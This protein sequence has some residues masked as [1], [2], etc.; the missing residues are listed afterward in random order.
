MKPS[1]TKSVLVAVLC[2]FG[3]SGAFAQLSGS[4]TIDASS[5]ASNNYTSVSAA[6]SALASSGVSGAVTFTI[7]DGTYTGQV[8]F[9]SAITGASST[10]TITFKSKSADAQKVIITN[11]GTYTVYMSGADY[12]SFEDVTIQSTS[13]GT[14]YV[15]YMTSGADYNNFQDCI[16]KGPQNTWTSYSVYCYQSEFNTWKGCRINGNY[17]GFRFWG[18]SDS[19]GAEDNVVEDCDISG[20]YYYGL[21]MY[22]QD[23]ITIKNCTIDS[24][25]SGIGYGLYHYRSHGSLIDG[26]EINTGYYP[27]YMGYSNYYYSGDTIQVQNNS[28]GNGQY[29]GLYQF[30]GNKVNYYHNSFEA[31]TGY[32]AVYM[33]NYQLNEVRVANNIFVSD[34][35]YYG[36]Y[37]YM[38]GTAYHPKYWDYNDYWFSNYTYHSY[39]NG[40]FANSLTALKGLYSSAFNQNSVEVDPDWVGVDR[41]TYTPGLNNVGIDKGVKTDIDGNARP[42]TKDTNVDIGPNDYWLADYDLD[43]FSLNSPLSVSLVSNQI[44]ATFKNAGSKTISNTDVYVEYSIDS[45]KT[46]VKDTMTITS[47]DPGKTQTFSFSKLWTPGRSGNFQVSVRINPQITGDPDSKDQKDWQVCSG[48][49]GT[50]TIGKYGDFKTPQDAVDA[51]KCGVA[52]PIVFDI[53]GGVYNGNLDISVLNG[54]SATNT[55]TFRS[56]STDSVT[57]QHSGSENT[58]ELEGADYVSFENI[59]ILATG[60]TG[61]AVHLMNSADYNSFTGCI[62]QSNPTA[63]NTASN[64]VVFSSS[65][66]SQWG[67]GNNGNYNVFRDNQMI[68]GY[69]GIS[70]QGQSTTSPIKGNEFYN[71]DITGAYYYGAYMYYCDSVVF[72]DNTIDNMRNTYA[73]GF[74]SYY[75]S[76]FSVERNYSRSGY[77]DFLGQANYYNWNNTALSTYANNSVMCDYQY[78]YGIYGYYMQRVGFYHN[79]ISSQGN[80]CLYAYYAQNNDIR[81]NIFYYG[82]GNYLWYGW[83]NSFIEFDYNDYVLTGSGNLAYMAGSVLSNLSALKGWNS[84]YNQNSF[85]EDP[86]WVDETSD[87]HVTSKFPKMYGANVGVE[88]DGDGDSRCKFAPSIGADEFAQ[89][90]LPPTASFLA[91]DTA[92]LGSPAIMLNSNK[93]SKLA[94]ATWFVNDTFASDSIHLQYTPTTTGMDTIMLVMENCSGTDTLEKLVYVSPILRAPKVDFAATST[95]VYTNEVIRFLDLSSGG[96]TSWSWDISPRRVY[97]PF[98]G[99][100]DDAWQFDTAQANPSGAFFYPG[101]Y[102]VKLKVANSFGADS[103]VRV[104]YIKVRQRSA[105][106]DIPWDTDGEYGTL[107]DNG[108][109]D[110]AYS[111]GLNGLNKCTYLISSCRGEIEFDVDQFDLGEDDYLRIYDG[112]D[113]NGR[114]L[115]DAAAYPDGMT[116]NKTNKS[117]K[118]SFTS[119]TGSAYFVFESDNSTQTVGKGF[120]IDWEYTPVT[121]TNPTAAITGVDTA[122]TGFPTVFENASTGNWSYVEWDIDNDGTIDGSGDFF[123]HTFNTAG[124]DT[125]MLKAYSLCAGADSIIKTI[126]IEDATKPAKPDFSASATV[127]SAGDTVSIDGS[128]DYCVSGFSWEI[129]PANYLLA[130]N[131]KLTDESIDIVFTKGGFFTI[132][133]EASNPKGKDSLIKTNYIQV[134]DYCTPSVVNIDDDLGISRVVFG[135]IDNSSTVGKSA[136]SNYTHISTEV[137]RGYSYQLTVERA[138]ANKSMNRKVWIDWNI[139]GDFDDAGELVAVEDE[140]NSLSFVDTIKIDPAAQAGKTRMRVGTSYKKQK[141]IACGPHAF[142]EFEDYGIIILAD[143]KTAPTLTLEGAKVDTIEVFGTWTEPG[144]SATDLVDGN[145]TSSVTVTNGLDNTVLG[146]YSIVYEVKDAEGNTATD[147]RTIVVLDRTM[148]THTLDGADSVW[149][150]IFTSYTDAGSTFDDNYDKA[151]TR[152]ELNNVDTA[153]LGVY[154]VTYCVTDGSGNGPVCVT[155]VVTVFDTIAPVIALEGNDPEIVDVFSNYEDAGFTAS[156]NHD[157]TVTTSGTWDGTVDELGTFTLTYTV[158]DPAGNSA[159]VTRTIEVVD[160]VAP[161]ITL[162]GNLVETVERWSDYTDANVT[163]TDNYDAV[164]DITVTPGGTFVNTQS[165]G[166]YTVTY[167]AE[168]LSGNT[169]TTVQRLVIVEHTNT[170]I[171]PIAENGYTVFPNPSN[172]LLVV[173]TN[174]DNGTST[175]LR[176]LDLTGKEVL[177]VGNHVVS[178][179]QFGVDLSS[180]ATGTYHLEITSADARVIEQVVIAR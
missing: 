7:S 3:I 147:N 67:Y 109:V 84:N 178:N 73:Y 46:W 117:V 111:P 96:A 99:I 153:N 4:Y 113:D 140:S 108:G 26:N 57:I 5:S 20:H 174:L 167:V 66:T 91:P 139:D 160:R 79:S 39:F 19:D 41:R 85:E 22:Y 47:M 62:I 168:D 123:S 69:Y 141:N 125:I 129:T 163:V 2:L 60:G 50:F 98:F 172:G 14:R 87:L 40:S 15:V 32:Y 133:L 136:Y 12:I 65:K 48:L 64:P 80:Y 17:Y 10:N 58:I 106:C 118:L 56:P 126:V 71:N 175:Q 130:N 171:D 51:L 166:V 161:E 110:G 132:E 88:L 34:G 135:D 93:A 102:Q 33:Y 121:W 61:F 120:A 11:T 89:V 149:V 55:V 43:V 103:V 90:V 154:E 165:E 27:F 25:Q 16:I 70:L 30:Y 156:D 131:T 159:S 179:G 148:P 146:S 97:N 54:A 6:A 13:T 36:M 59:K 83:N 52:G 142:G 143:D 180:L 124:T 116:G 21:Y 78:S 170:T 53:A 173:R 138:T 75:L 31:N 119:Q 35:G 157:Y 114:P 72:H 104:A 158:T 164:V 151:M 134:L 37:V 9:N 68:G 1:F 44:Q 8:S 144:F 81:N 86:E 29:Y 76:N 74:Y 152:D 105:L 127:V 155:R 45:G 28:V 49:L 176:V 82:G 95:D 112:E 23:G 92:W 162:N 38:G 145:L 18:N 128:A 94:G 150:Q 24:A 122:C 169:S 177:N 100:Y 137:E 107:Y 63:I 115:W 77:G 42:N 101:V